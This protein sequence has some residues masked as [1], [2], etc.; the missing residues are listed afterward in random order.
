M[1]EKVRVKPGEGAL[2]GHQCLLILL[3]PR[4][5]YSLRPATHSGEIL[6]ED[7]AAVGREGLSH[8][9]TVCPR[10]WRDVSAVYGLGTVLAEP[11]GKSGPLL[12]EQ[13]QAKTLS[14][15]G[16]FSTSAGVCFAQWRTVLWGCGLSSA[17]TPNPIWILCTQGP[18]GN[19]LRREAEGYD[20]S[21]R[22]GTISHGCGSSCRRRQGR[23]GV[24][25]K[26]QCWVLAG[27]LT[28]Q[29]AWSRE[30]PLKQERVF[31]AYPCPGSAVR[32]APSNGKKICHLQTPLQNKVLIA[33]R[34]L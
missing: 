18:K 20:P 19:Q 28:A 32:I 7:V 5:A 21:P 24:E 12:E 11:M 9:R 33:L 1:Q 17:G 27:E 2:Q 14:Q 4:R 13:L 31:L 34:L 25:S 16:P 8:V 3:D 10:R 29:E 6:P 15:R 22:Q 23:W 30:E 26:R